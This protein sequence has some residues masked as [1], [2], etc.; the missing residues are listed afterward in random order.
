MAVARLLPLLIPAIIGLSLAACQPRTN[1]PAC[2]AG[3]LCLEYGN[4]ADPLSLD[5]QLIQ[6]TNEATIVMELIEGLIADGPDGKPTPGVAQS[7][8][9]SPDGLVWT[10]HL[11]PEVW[12]DGVPLTA[13]DFVYAYRRILDPKTASSYAYLVY[14]LKN[15]QA[16]NTGKAPLETVGAKALDPRTL[17]LTL[18]H[19]APYLLQLLK[20]QS[21]FP[22][23]RHVVERWSATWT[24]PSHFVTNGPY[25]LVEWRLSDYVRIEKNPRFHDADKVC[26][27]RVDFYPTNDPISAER[28]VLRG[29]LDINSSIQSNRVQFLRARRRSADYV[30]AFPFLTTWYLVFNGRDVPALKDVRVRQA[31]SMAIDRD[32]ITGKLLRAG[33]IPVTSFVPALVAGYPAPG[34]A[35]PQ[36]YWAAWPLAQRQAEARRLLELAGYGPGHPLAL[37]M[38]TSNRPGGSLTIQAI[39]ADWKSI[40]VRMSVRQEDGIIVY[41]SYDIRDFQTGIAGWVADFDDAMTF[42]G[43]MKSDTGAQNY[44][45]YRNPAYDALLD[46]ADHEA[47]GRVRA[48]YLAE[49]ERMILADADVAPLYNDVNTNLV[50]PH[51]TGWVDN[52][53][54]IH[55]IRF[56]CRND[57]GS[58]TANPAH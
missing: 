53:E 49:A 56:L 1:R 14:V 57:A 48:G 47:D 42:L 13:D 28:R 41:Q 10:F 17:Q 20:H 58:R 50:N 5:P 29:E 22:V 39:Q 43:L 36:P 26:F 31:L 21:F 2:P 40:G 4:G 46:K 32:F 15:G 51:I 8:E 38:K 16:A 54:D 55:P 18:E 11:R 23:P 35:R 12:S 3:A 44:G 34:E 6:A 9:T 30:H 19:P 25:R 27:H 37:Q 52:A 45:D 24:Q 7:W 33:Q